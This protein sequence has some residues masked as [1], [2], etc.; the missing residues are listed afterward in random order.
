MQYEIPLTPVAQSFQIQI[1]ETN[2]TLRVQYAVAEEG[3]WFLDIADAT[4]ADL[5]TGIPLVCGVDLLAQ[6]RHLGLGVTLFMIT[7][8]DIPPAYSELGTTGHLVFEAIT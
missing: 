2:Y 6:H 5:V 4:G 3:G 7:P 8:D 1:I